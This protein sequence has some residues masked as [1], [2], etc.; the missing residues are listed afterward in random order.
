LVI[1][2]DKNLGGCRAGG[3]TE[4]IFGRSQLPGSAMAE[5]SE[6]A[7]MFG[8]GIGPPELLIVGVI[9]VL[10]FGKRLP[11]VGRSLGKSIVE[12]KKGMHDIKAEVDGATNL[13][14]TTSRTSH[15]NSIDDYEEATAPK[16]EPP[17]HEPTEAKT[18]DG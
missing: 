3:G 15:R 8:L 4:F 10:L 12:F 18:A 6:G 17:A 11:E 5:E 9:A 1:G 2:G 14:A 16:F 7:M 13:T